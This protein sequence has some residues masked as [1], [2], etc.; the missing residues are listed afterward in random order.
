MAA[1]GMLIYS[2]GTV[3]TFPYGVLDSIQGGPLF[4]TVAFIIYIGGMPLVCIP[5]LAKANAQR[6]KWSN[7]SDS[8]ALA[9][10][11]VVDLVVRFLIT[12]SALFWLTKPTVYA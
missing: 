10:R 11:L 1:A 4:I 12:I 6:L 8:V 3:V 2:S 7:N 9:M 5:G